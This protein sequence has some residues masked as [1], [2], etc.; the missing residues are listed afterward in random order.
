[1]CVTLAHIILFSCVRFKLQCFIYA[2][3]CV[4]GKPEYGKFL[5][6][7]SFSAW[8][9]YCQCLTLTT[10]VPEK[11]KHIMRNVMLC[12]QMHHCCLNKNEKTKINIFM[13]CVL[14][15]LSFWICVSNIWF[16]VIG[17]VHLSVEKPTAS[18]SMIA[19]VTERTLS[20]K[21]SVKLSQTQELATDFRCNNVSYK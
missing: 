4:F 1:M 11:A 7:T 13:K 10:S 21:R 12:L 9:N 5:T 17:C 8:A 15:L 16:Y 2:H 20:V 19:F 3:M 14:E 18:W 6:K